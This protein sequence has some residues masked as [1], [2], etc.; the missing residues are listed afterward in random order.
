MMCRNCGK[1]VIYS[2]LLKQHY[3]TYCQSSSY[4]TKVKIKGD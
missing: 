2:K 1:E 3:C 4:I